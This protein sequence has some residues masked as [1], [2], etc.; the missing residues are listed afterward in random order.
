MT[1][2]LCP[3]DQEIDYVWEGHRTKLGRIE[4]NARLEELSSRLVRVIAHFRY[5]DGCGNGHNTFSATCSLYEDTQSHIRTNPSKTRQGT[6]TDYRLVA[7]GQQHDLI[8]ELFPDLEKYL[9]WHLASTDGPL[10]YIANSL[11][12]A[13]K[14]GWCDGKPND[15]PNLEYFRSTAVWPDATQS[16]IDKPRKVLERALGRRLPI[17]MREF[18]KAMQ[19]LGFTY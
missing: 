8:K 6:G 13:G 15:P 4:R 9:K 16:V 11:Y 5:G 3:K 18:M 2:L 10:H 19:E 17:V 14:N 1:S 7:C 12:W